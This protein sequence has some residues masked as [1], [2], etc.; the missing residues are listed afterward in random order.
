MWGVLLLDALI[1]QTPYLFRGI[2]EPLRAK[3]I[4]FRCLNLLQ[5]LPKIVYNTTM[6]TKEIALKAIE[7]LPPNA[8]WEDIQE[9]INFVVGVRKG[10]RELDEGKGI[11][12]D[13]VKEEF[14]E[15]LTD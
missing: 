14:A 4:P 3:P 13:K 8:S 10:L 7:R 2:Q 6:T 12:H 11:P 9:R 1:P 5:N 15:W